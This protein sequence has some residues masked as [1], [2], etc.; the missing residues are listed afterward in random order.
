MFSTTTSIS[1]PWRLVN[2]VQK[3]IAELNWQP[4]FDLVSGLQDSFHQDYLAAGRDQAEV[5]FSV[6]DE[7]LA[8]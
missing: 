1:I 7:I 3:A 8:A 4:Q 2:S 5:N 6:D